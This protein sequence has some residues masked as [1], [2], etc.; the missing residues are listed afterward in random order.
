MSIEPQMCPGT[1]PMIVSLTELE[2]M[3]GADEQV[4]ECGSTLGGAT[5]ME[6]R[7]RAYN[8]NYERIME[9]V[10]PVPWLAEPQEAT[11]MNR[12]KAANEPKVETYRQL[13]LSAI[14]GDNYG[15]FV[16]E[17][18]GEGYSVWFKIFLL[19][20]LVALIYY[21]VKAQY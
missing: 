9:K 10:M 15:T 3:P 20:L 13:E 6:V 14:P 1:Q 12:E 4:H 21:V 7:D 19:L 16:S 11:F 17:G 2:G 5:F 18:F 8:P